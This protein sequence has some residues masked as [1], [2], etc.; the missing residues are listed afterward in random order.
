MLGSSNIEEN[1]QASTELSD[2]PFAHKARK[3]MKWKGTKRKDLGS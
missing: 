3:T 2:R 1:P